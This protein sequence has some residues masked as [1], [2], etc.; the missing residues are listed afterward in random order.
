MDN[1]FSEMIV[2]AKPTDGIFIMRSICMVLWLLGLF[3]CFLI[4]IIGIAAVILFGILTYKVIQWTS[5]EYEYSLF[6]GKLDIDAIMGQKRRKNKASVDLNSCMMVAKETSSKL[7][8]VRNPMYKI[9][10]YSKGFKNGKRY[11]IVI[12]FGDLKQRILFE[13][14]ENMLQ[15]IKTTIP[16]KFFED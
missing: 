12:A 3:L 5:L 6:D 16:G 14:D 1:T 4:P 15:A 10:D 8:A 9:K 13:P 7:D 11:E 2:K